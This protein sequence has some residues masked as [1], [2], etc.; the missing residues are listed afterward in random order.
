LLLQ[1]A[2]GFVAVLLCILNTASLE[3]AVDLEPCE[4]LRGRGNK[5]E[6][7]QSCRVDDG[8][9]CNQA[10]KGLQGLSS[11]TLMK[12]AKED[13]LHRSINQLLE[14]EP[15]GRSRVRLPTESI[16]THVSPKEC[17]AVQKVWNKC[18]QVGKAARE[19]GKCS[20][21]L[22][23]HFSRKEWSGKGMEI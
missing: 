5:P 21:V 19:I 22:E 13:L 17:H 18:C 1:F 3:L 11:T 2:C 6:Q 20:G 8:R 10:L 15:T 4:R 16:L 12:L 14:I 9:G 7:G 23:G